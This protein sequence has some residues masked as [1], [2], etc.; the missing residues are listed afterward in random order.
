[1]SDDNKNT[2]KEEFKIKGEHLLP[3][4]HTFSFHQGSRYLRPFYDR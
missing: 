2:K 1:M 4:H 3:F